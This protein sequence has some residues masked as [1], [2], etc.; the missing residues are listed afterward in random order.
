ME[1]PMVTG[2]GIIMVEIMQTAATPAAVISDG[3]LS[4]LLFRNNNIAS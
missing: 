1:L 4:R 2:L 3:M